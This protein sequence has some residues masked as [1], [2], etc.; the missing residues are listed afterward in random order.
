MPAA[1]RTD[2]ITVEGAVDRTQELLTMR[3]QE[4]QSA[5]VALKVEQGQAYGR[6][7]DTG[8]WTP[9][10]ENPI[11]SAAKIRWAIWSPPR[12]CGHWPPPTPVMT[13][14][15]AGFCRRLTPTA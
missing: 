1:A 6:M 3:L 14:S 4:G 11:S 15:A 2:T 10:D 13:S 9:L 8:E 12:M 7:A 5:P